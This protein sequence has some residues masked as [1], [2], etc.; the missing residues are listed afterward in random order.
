[1]EVIGEGRHERVV[2]TWDKFKAHV[3]AKAAAAGVAPLA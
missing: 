1:V 3:N 2:V